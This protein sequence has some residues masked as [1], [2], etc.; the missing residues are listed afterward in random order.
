MGAGD[1]REAK[2]VAVL[3][4]ISA[5]SFSFLISVSLYAVRKW[6]V[7]A[8]TADEAIAKAASPLFGPLGLLITLQVG[9]L[10]GSRF[11]CLCD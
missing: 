9:I 7:H 6:V 5:F 10:A 8:Y 4:V 11:L 3:G 2:Q 1:A